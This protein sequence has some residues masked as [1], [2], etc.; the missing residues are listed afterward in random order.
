MAERSHINGAADKREAPFTINMPS[1]ADAYQVLLLQAADDGRGDALFGESLQRARTEALPFMLGKEF[2]SVYLE[3]PLLGQPYLDV[4]VLYGEL[5]PGTRVESPLAGEHAA[6]FD[7]FT[8][9]RAKD[10]SVTCG[11]ELDTKNE[12]IPTAA[13]HFQPRGR[14]ELVRPFCEAVDEPDRADLYLN[15]AARMPDGWPL[16]FF[17]MFRGRPGSPLRV[18]GYI[19]EPEIQ[20]CADDFRHL[21]GVFETVGF[22]AYDDAMLKQ[23]SALMAVAPEQVDFQFDVYPDGSLGN[24]FAID[25]MFGIKQPEMVREVFASGAGAQ[26][27]GL[28]ESWGAADGRW[29]LGADAAFA[30]ALPVQLDDGENGRYAFTLMPQWVKARWTDTVLQPSKLY[31]FANGSVVGK[32]DQPSEMVG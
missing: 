4:T 9:I 18:C 1:H 14:T 26:V 13:V 31:S 17:G 25:V 15:Q 8:P 23:V 11:F 19:P 16:S 27:M 5:D 2:P 32:S 10:D 6:M 28:L 29:K 12:T 7:W 21:A 3:C 22:S 30:R 20:A 24:V